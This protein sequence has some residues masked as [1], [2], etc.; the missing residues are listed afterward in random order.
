MKLNPKSAGPKFGPR[1][2]AVTAAMAKRTDVVE[3]LQAGKPVELQLPD[4]PATIEPADVWIT[5]KVEKG[6]GGIADH[7]TQILL[8]GRITPDL[9]LEGLARE[10]VRHV[11]NARKDAGL[12]MDDRIVLSLHTGD[13]KLGRQSRNIATTS[14]PRRWSCNGRQG[15]LGLMPIVWRP[16]SRGPR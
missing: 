7:G 1:L 4:G 10:V 16:R 9:E 14:P 5:P 13:S 3:L 12:E 8:D 2:A 15:R 6:W 11:Q